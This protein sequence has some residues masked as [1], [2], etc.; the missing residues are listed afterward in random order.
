MARLGRLGSILRL[1]SFGWVRTRVAALWEFSPEMLGVVRHDLQAGIVLSNYCGCL[2]GDW[3][4]DEVV[5]ELGVWG[6]DLHF[7]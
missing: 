6:F 2:P 1:L 5:Y 7:D 4:P 3:N